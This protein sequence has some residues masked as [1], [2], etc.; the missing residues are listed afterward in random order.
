M[1]RTLLHPEMLHAQ[2][3]QEAKATPRIGGNIAGSLGE[4]GGGCVV[5]CVLLKSSPM[6]SQL[7]RSLRKSLADLAFSE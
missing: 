2:A 4:G 5:S 7:A 1:G 6:Q 3:L